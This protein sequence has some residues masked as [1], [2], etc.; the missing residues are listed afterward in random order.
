MI[1]R[2]HPIGKEKANLKLFS[3]E[4]FGVFYGALLFRGVWFESLWVWVGGF[5]FSAHFGASCVYCLYIQWRLSLL[6]NYYS[7]KK[8]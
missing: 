4:G 3:V 8:T 5:G 6:I 2:V 1:Q 7:L